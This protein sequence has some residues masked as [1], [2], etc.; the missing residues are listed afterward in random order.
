MTE[1]RD[2]ELDV[3]QLRVL[4]ADDMI[5]GDA[6]SQTISVDGWG[7]E[8]DSSAEFSDMDFRMVDE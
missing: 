5:A 8:W 3:E 6:D 7:N 2:S 1:W 4:A